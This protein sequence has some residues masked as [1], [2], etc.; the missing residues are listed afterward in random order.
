MRHPNWKNPRHSPRTAFLVVGLALLV[1]GMFT[2]IDRVLFFNGSVTM[3][4]RVLHQQG[5]LV[6]VAPEGRYSII[7]VERPIISGRGTVR[8]RK[9]YKPGRIVEIR[10]DTAT[11]PVEAY[12]NSLYSLW[13]LPVGSILGGL[14]L[15]WLGLATSR[16]LKLDPV[17]RE[18]Y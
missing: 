18:R 4:A 3:R 12:M 9:D 2:T 14:F 11:V 7:W 5:A 8:S 16:P 10:A 15:L 13:F 1:F 17:D 6:A